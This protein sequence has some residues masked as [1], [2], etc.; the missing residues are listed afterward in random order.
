MITNDQQFGPLKN[1]IDH[2]IPPPERRNTRNIHH[3]RRKLIGSHAQCQ[4]VDA[5]K[6][7]DTAL[8][9]HSVADCNKCF[10][11]FYPKRKKFS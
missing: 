6:N 4:D 2:S 3:I 9:L 10:T 11:S 8:M 1:K 5:Q 7:Q